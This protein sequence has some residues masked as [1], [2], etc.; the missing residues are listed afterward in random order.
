MKPWNDPRITS[1]T[2]LSQYD[3]RAWL[4]A[5]RPPLAFEPKPEPKPASTVAMNRE[6]KEGWDRWCRSHV[7]DGLDMLAL[8]VGEETGAIER[9][10]NAKIDAVER[11][12][13]EMRA[14]AQVERSA[15]IIDL[16][17]LPLRK[18]DAA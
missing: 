16:P 13:G 18:R 17:R 2:Q 15:R 9:R 5:G 8:V 4:A 14:E 1:A 6:A 10:L 12:L 11:A 7:Q 3:R